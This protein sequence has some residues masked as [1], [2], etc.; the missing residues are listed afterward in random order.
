MMASGK[1]HM[2]G[3]RERCCMVV[4]YIM[5]AYFGAVTE[6]NTDNVGVA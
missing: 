5:V 6:G 3:L 4:L 1:Q 2:R